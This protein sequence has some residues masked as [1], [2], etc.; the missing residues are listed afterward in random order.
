M[1]SSFHLALMNE[2]DS[3]NDEARRRAAQG[4]PTGTLVWSRAQTGARG[5]RGRKWESP[6]GNLYCSL[7]LRPEKP[8]AEVPQLS[9]VAALAVSDTVDSAL[10]AGPRVRCKWPND[11]L[12]EGRKVSGVLLES[13][14]QAN[15]LD[16][17]VVGIGVNVNS[18]PADDAVD[19]PATSMIE[20]G[21]T[22]TVERVLERLASR[23]DHWISLWKTKG[24]VPIRRE[25]LGRAAGQGEAIRVRL[26]AETFHGVF[27]DL[28]GDGALVVAV[29]G[30]GRRRVTAGEVFLG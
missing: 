16:C 30:G 26:G 22:L 10:P 7:L 15:R 24:F 27:E 6:K 25:W 5:R 12:V 11:V 13:H 19:T 9:F 29:A 8:L 14:A 17:L 4:A 2:V 23:L 20:H 1:P 21:A 18:R 3:T 28:D